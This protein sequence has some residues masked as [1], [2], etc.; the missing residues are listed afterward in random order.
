VLLRASVVLQRL[1]DEAP[2]GHF[3]LAWLMT[4]LHRRSYGMIMLLLALVATA[5][6]I[7][8]VAGLFLTIP[9]LQLIAGRPAPLFPRR[10]ALRPLPT[11]HLA[12][13]VQRAVPVL[14]HVEEFSHPRWAT[15]LEATKRVVGTVVMLLSIALV[16]APIPLSCVAPLVIALISIAYIEED[17]LLLSIAML[18]AVIVLTARTRRSGRR[19]AVRNGSAT[20]G[21]GHR[22]QSL[23]MGRGLDAALW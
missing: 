6:G 11:R 23:G 21:S 4:G 14:T 3:T 15:A 20:S 8:I 7:S 9:A 19:S 18:V 13:L 10:I 22:G 12:A 16:F 17:G 1:H 2:T 5:P